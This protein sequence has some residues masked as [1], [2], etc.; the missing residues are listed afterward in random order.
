M[1][2]D[3]SGLLCQTDVAIEVP[4]FKCYMHQLL[5]ALQALHDRGI[6]HRDVKAS[7]V[8]INNGGVLKLADFGLARFY[9]DSWI[10]SRPSVFTNRVVTLAYRP[11]E[12]LLGATDYGPEVDMWSAGC[13]LYELY[14]KTQLFRGEDEVDQLYQIFQK[15]GSIDEAAWPGAIKLPW[16]HLV[17]PKAPFPSTLNKSLVECVLLSLLWRRLLTQS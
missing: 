8:L 5:C 11:P 4:H 3:L 15:C 6:V 1:E 10:G 13:V 7:N 16:Y 9:Q 14:S 17:K 2:H 12:L